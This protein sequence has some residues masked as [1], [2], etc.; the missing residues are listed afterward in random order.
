M[1][2]VGNGDGQWVT[3]DSLGFVKSDAVPLTISIVLFLV[4]FK[5]LHFNLIKW[6]YSRFLP[7][8]T[9]VLHDTTSA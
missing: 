8:P 2:R 7:I 4:P 9:A 1:F 6:K 3:E 5:N